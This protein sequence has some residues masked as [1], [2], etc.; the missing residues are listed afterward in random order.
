MAANCLAS[1]AAASS[2]HGESIALV[3]VVPDA[4]T[5]SLDEQVLLKMDINTALQR[6]SPQFRDVLVSRFIAGESAAEIG[7]R[8]GTNDQRLD[9]RSSSR[10]KKRR[11]PR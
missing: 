1:L 8:Y 4:G 7:R 9:T 5:L 3:D 10:N 2:D 11:G 6:L